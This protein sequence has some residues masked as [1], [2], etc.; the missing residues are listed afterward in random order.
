MTRDR[1]MLWLIGVGIVLAVFCAAL[2]IVDKANAADPPTVRY[3]YFK[4]FDPTFV[5]IEKGFFK[6]AGVNVVLTGNYPSGPSTVQGGALGQVDAGLCSVTGIS[7]A[8]ASGAADVRGIADIQWDSK[9]APLQRFYVKDD[10]SIRK[11]ADLKGKTIA[12]N[13]FGASFHTTWLIALDKAGL[14]A[15]DVKFVNMPFAQQ[16]QALLTGLVDAIGLID[17]FNRKAEVDGGARLLYRGVDVT[18]ERH[19]SLLWFTTKYQR[20]NTDAVRRFVKAYQKSIRWIYGNPRGA[21]GIMWKYLGVHPKYQTKHR[22]TENAHVVMA[23]VQWWLDQ[24]RKIGTLDDGG[25]T[26]PA[27]VATVRFTG[28]PKK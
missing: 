8:R 17:P 5:G 21:A 18:G 7:L 2:F 16:Q 10:S 23:D 12:V 22:Y 28:V 25:K 14:S 19:I 27:A 24:M 26:T 4:A 13:G 3:A 6:E 1:L 9:K 11:V 15:S 20:E